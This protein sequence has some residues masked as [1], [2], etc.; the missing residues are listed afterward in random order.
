MDDPVQ[1]ADL[2]VKEGAE[3]RYLTRSRNAFREPSD[4]GVEPGFSR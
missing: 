3:R 1:R 4:F 2:G